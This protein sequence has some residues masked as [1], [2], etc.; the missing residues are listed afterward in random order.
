MKLDTAT[1]AI[2]QRDI[3]SNS[4]NSSKTSSTGDGGDTT[5]DIPP[6][7]IR[8]DALDALRR[9]DRVDELSPNQIAQHA[10]QLMDA[11]ASLMDLKLKPGPKV[12][13]EPF[14]RG[15]NVATLVGA[16]IPI[17]LLGFG[18]GKAVT[19]LVAEALARNG[20]ASAIPYTA[21]ISPILI[22]LFSVFLSEPIGGAIRSSGPTHTSPDAKAYADYVTAR[23]KM[24][25]AILEKNEVKKEK[26]T[27]IMADIVDGLIDREREKDSR[28][29]IV[30][31]CEKPSRNPDGTV[32]EGQK[33][34][35]AKVLAYCMARSFITDDLAFAWFIPNHFFSA[36]AASQ[37][38][39]VLGAD[40]RLI[41]A[42]VHLFMGC[43]STIEVLI[44]QDWLRSRIQGVDALT[45]T[46]KGTWK[47]AK[48]DASSKEEFKR[49]VLE[50]MTA[51][52]K[53]LE[54]CSKALETAIS[55]KARPG[56]PFDPDLV[57]MRKR[58]NRAIDTVSAV[59]K[60]ASR[61]AVKARRDALAVKNPVVG[62][63]QKI[64]NTYNHYGGQRGLQ[65][66]AFLDGYAIRTRNGAKATAYFWAL[67][68]TAT[69]SCILALSA[70]SQTP[71]SSAPSP[72]DY[73]NPYAPLNATVFNAS[74]TPDS[75][76][77]STGNHTAVQA[78]TDQM[79]AI[80]R[81]GSGTI[82][83]ISM[84]TI[85]HVALAV[86]SETAA[87]GLYIAGVKVV[88][89][90]RE[91]LGM[92]ELPPA[93]ADDSPQDKL[94]REAKGIRDKQDEI[95]NNSHEERIGLSGSQYPVYEPNP[96]IQGRLPTTTDISGLG[97][98]SS[99]QARRGQNTQGRLPATTPVN[100]LGAVTPPKPRRGQKRTT[101][102]AVNITNTTTDTTRT[103]RKASSTPTTTTVATRAPISSTP[104]RR[105]NIDGESD[106]GS[107]SEGVSSQDD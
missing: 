80:A 87:Y 31:G 38:A 73:M 89:K 35:S 107:G 11:I 59:L 12:K 15:W 7:T 100:L 52:R 77:D 37:M 61:D 96:N 43:V 24:Q 76:L 14:S 27:K 99:R 91:F 40:A 21:F 36:G 57:D 33:D 1:T 46:D 13:A 20:F 42:L 47:L 70:L 49:G 45:E 101:T 103:T 69:Y 85:R 26:Y 5:I 60:S 88:N 95:A 104:R 9:F 6:L 17:Y 32:A 56:H 94:K 82:I 18:M 65:K 30:S 105:Y 86:L 67:M 58:V 8:T 23:R 102:N 3:S 4:S 83:T 74:S 19:N 53:E 84:W 25:V 62:I 72:A 79:A 93:E 34:P 92:E 44:T 28:V 75:T 98:F 71:A 41:D 106:D 2:P 10:P 97:P 81:S 22:P 48:V 16:A 64:E 55:A 29:R 50:I 51:L 66:T 63:A 54:A 68:P 39:K 90:A 78:A